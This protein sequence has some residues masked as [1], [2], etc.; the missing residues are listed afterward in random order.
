MIEEVF[1]MPIQGEEKQVYVVLTDKDIDDAVTILM[2]RHQ[3]SMRC[4]ASAYHTQRARETVVLMFR[5][6]EVN[7]I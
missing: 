2:D 5:Q 6:W 3:G 1:R 4:S 7:K